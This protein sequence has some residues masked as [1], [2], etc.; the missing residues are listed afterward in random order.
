M[1]NLGPIRSTA[2]AILDL[3]QTICEDVGEHHAARHVFIAIRSIRSIEHDTPR[4]LLEAVESFDPWTTHEDIHPYLQ[5]VSR[6]CADVLRWTRE[7]ELW[8]ERY[9]LQVMC[10]VLTLRLDP[11]A[12]EL[13]HGEWQRIAEVF[14]KLLE[15]KV[16][17]TDRIRLHHGEL[18]FDPDHD[19]QFT[20]TEKIVF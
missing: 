19:F 9:M 4:D 8:R 1:V 10:P 14:G 17:A 2:C 3:A 11:T 16:E 7:E 12:R 18:T 6:F 20:W 13:V 15:Y 5:S